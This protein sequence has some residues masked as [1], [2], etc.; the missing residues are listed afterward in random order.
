MNIKD[1]P[2]PTLQRAD[3]RKAGTLES[4]PDELFEKLKA[5]VDLYERENEKS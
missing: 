4:M 5:A 3:T 2:P 1:Y